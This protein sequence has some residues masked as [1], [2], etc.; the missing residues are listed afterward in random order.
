MSRYDVIPVSVNDY[1]KKAKKRLPNFLFDYIE[2][3]ANA[4]ETLHSNTS[5]FKKFNLKQFVMRDVSKVSTSTTLL[6]E[7]ISM[8][9]ALAPIGMAGLFARRG[10]IQAAQAAT[11]NNVPYT[12]STVGVC[13]IEEVNKATHKPF[14]FQLYMLRDRGL[15]LE[16]LNGAQAAGCTTLVFTVDLAVPGLRLRDFRNGML[17]GGVK[18]K[19]SQ[20]AQLITRPYWL[21]DVG[22]KG[23]PHSFGNLK[24]KVTSPNNLDDYKAFIDSQFDPSATWDDIAWLRSHWQGNVLIK[25]IMEVND[26]QEAVNAGADGIVISNHGGRQL[27][28]TSSTITK[29]P[30]IVHAVGSQTE[31]LLD[32]GIRSGVDVVK[33]LALGA[34]GILIGR[35]W[36]YAMAAQ[37]ENGINKLLALFQKEI[38]S[39]MGLM[40]VDS[41]DKINADLIER[42]GT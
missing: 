26:A 10:E 13:S 32:G 33:A 36:V 9:L 37:G 23:K 17:D 21:Y 16:M 24:H 31:I 40:G 42:R 3:G 5:D 29:L 38:A 35:P 4:E 19:I 30:D 7:K 14:W 8:P 27:D 1:Q 22:I 18:G 28:G 39:T 25:G 20:A 12:L 11:K 41:I 6:G 34:K 15:V 2:G